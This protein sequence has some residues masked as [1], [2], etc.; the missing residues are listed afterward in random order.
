[1]RVGYGVTVLANGIKADGVDGIGHYTSELG[2]ELIK[3]NLATVTPISFGTPVPKQLFRGSAETITLE[4]FSLLTAAAAVWPSGIP[5]SHRLKEKID[6]FHA[7]DHLV[8]RLGNIPVLAT[9]MDAIPLSHPEWI[10]QRLKT[11][12]ISVWRH[13]IRWADHIITISEYSKQEI[14]KYFG[15][16]EENISVVSLGVAK[17]Y[18]DRVDPIISA[19]ILKKYGLPKMYYLFVGTLQPR[20][21]LERLLRAHEMLPAD[22]KKS[23]PLVIVGREGWGCNELVKAINKKEE[24]GQV[25]W[26]KYLP[27]TEVI[28]LMQAA[29]ALVYPSL[30]EGFGLPVL[31]AFASG[32]PVVTSNTSALP[33]V[34]GDAALLA[35]PEDIESI[36]DGMKR[37]VED[38]D[39]TLTMRKKGLERARKMS[40]SACAKNTM[41]LYHQF[42]D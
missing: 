34:A 40:W 28:A 16:K 5:G 35:D 9:V 24:G 11:L 39:L 23:F 33:E 4:R 14:V 27:D 12:K 29:Q 7:T 25:Y 18:F 13:T 17:R 26:L 37:V 36:M 22:L 2:N 20:K 32:L 38:S 31:E 6:L 8:P 21:N 30:C 15:I 3:H 42:V 1:M 10:T 41:S 19:H